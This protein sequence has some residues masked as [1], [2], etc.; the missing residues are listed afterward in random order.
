MRALIPGF[1][2]VPGGETMVRI[3]VIA[4]AVG[5]C[6]AAAALLYL[7]RQKGK[8][9]A[10]GWILLAVGVLLVINHGVQLML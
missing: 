8:N 5:V 7:R 6:L 1:I 2:P 10:P 9:T 4:L 3:S